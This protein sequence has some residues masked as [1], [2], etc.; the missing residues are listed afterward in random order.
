MRL[1][2]RYIGVTIM[3]SM[4]LVLLVL[5]GA[6]VFITFVNELHDIGM[7]NYG[8]LQSFLYV[9]LTLPQIVY[10]MFPMAALIG[11]LLGLSL[12]ASH[13]E[14][15][16]MQTSGVSVF[17]IA[18]A[19]IRVTILI[20]I[21]I[22]LVGEWIG[23]GL[24]YLAV[25]QK[26]AAISGTSALQTQHSAWLREDKNFVHIEEVVSQ[27]LLQGITVYQFD[28]GGQLKTVQY[29]KKGKLEGNQWVFSDIDQTNIE[30]DFVTVKKL[31]KQIWHLSLKPRLL[32]MDNVNPEDQALPKLYRY[33]RYRQASGLDNTEYAFT[34]WKRVMQPV[35]TLVVVLLA[36]PFI[37]GPLRTVTIG[38][39]ILAGVG[40]G[41]S[42][43][44]LNQFL[45]PFSLVYQVPPMLAAALPTCIFIFVS[46]ILILRTR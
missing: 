37:F 35:S 25:V 33:M 41:F 27:D 8:L 42:F 44:L 10:Q 11:V 40:V 15:I 5:V 26:A 34:F 28:D 21:V 12:L 43:Y 7:G 29:A 36:I 16:V 1:L 13:S 4:L 6:E 17:R 39:R 14:L 31:S 30:K 19:V 3:R 23:P 45:G 24:A 38:L 20:L 22:T 9:A 32:T 2:S 46:M 18:Y